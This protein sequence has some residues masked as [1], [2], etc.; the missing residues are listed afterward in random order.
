MIQRIQSLYLLLAAVVL[1]T[2]AALVCTWNL[3]FVA[4]VALSAVISL[5]TIFL[6]SNRKLQLRLI[7]VTIALDVIAPIIVA[8]QMGIEAWK[9]QIIPGALLVCALILAFLARY[10][11]SYDERL[12]RS[13]D[14]LR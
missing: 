12:V 11:V 3:L 10:R 9:E 2:S 8:V 14:R 4:L 5:T 1:G 6:Y 7:S 13:A